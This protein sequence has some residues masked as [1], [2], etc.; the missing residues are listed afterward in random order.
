MNGGLQ[1]QDSANPQFLSKTATTQHSYNAADFSDRTTSRYE[2]TVTVSTDERAA[3][4]YDDTLNNVLAEKTSECCQVECTRLDSS[5]N[6][7]A[8][9]NSSAKYIADN[10][11]RELVTE[12][13]NR[14]NYEQSCTPVVH[15]TTPWSSAE[16]TRAPSFSNV[17]IEDTQVPPSV[18][19]CNNS[20]VLQIQKPKLKRR[21]S[22]HVWINIPCDSY[23]IPSIVND[24]DANIQQSTTNS[25]EVKLQ[26]NPSYGMISDKHTTASHDETVKLRR[27]PAAHGH[28]YEIVPFK[29]RPVTSINGGTSKAVKG[30][31]YEVI[32]YR[33]SRCASASIGSSAGKPAKMPSNT[34]NLKH[35]SVNF[36]N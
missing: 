14:E 27:K 16:G 34:K 17:T 1:K 32:P 18:T 23:G 36:L 3:D 15:K 22:D 7:V 4:D 21:S 2:N 29:R 10:S 33:R 31:V 11:T 35:R 25:D 13:N 6:E 20:D 9:M 26:R 5:N 30:H 12:G 24:S 8:I 19:S 28:L